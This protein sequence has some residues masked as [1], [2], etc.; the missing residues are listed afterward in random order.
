MPSTLESLPSVFWTL[1]R[2]EMDKVDDTVAELERLV[3]K[4]KHHEKGEKP[5]PPDIA[6]SADIFLERIKTARR[7]A[8]IAGP[9]RSHWFVELM[10]RV[11]AADIWLE[12]FRQ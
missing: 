9:R 12:R 2:E 8:E 5:T 4:A 3:R 10:G 1:S 6:E 7:I 11:S